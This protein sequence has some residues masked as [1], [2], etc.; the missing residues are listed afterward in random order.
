MAP[1]FVSLHLAEN[2]VRSPDKRAFGQSTY[3]RCRPGTWTRQSREPDSNRWSPN[4]PDS[5]TRKTRIDSS[6]FRSEQKKMKKIGGIQ[7]CTFTS[8]L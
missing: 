5:R 2:P 1:D 7:S 6:V 4:H 3:S 8:V